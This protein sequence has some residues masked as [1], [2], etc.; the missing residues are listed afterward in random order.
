MGER[1]SFG[2][3][4]DP[5][6][7][8]KLQKIFSKIITASEH[9]LTKFLSRQMNPPSSQIVHNKLASQLLC[10]LLDWRKWNEL[11]LAEVSGILPSVISAHLSGQRPIRPQHLAAYL[12]VLDRQERSALLDAW[13]QDN[14]RSE[15]ATN[16][17]EGTKT[18]SMRSVEENRCR[19]LDWW[20][21]AIAR[22]SKIAKIFRRFSTKAAFKHPLQLLSLVSTIGLQFQ[23]RLLERACSLFARVK[24]A[25]VALVSLILALCQPGKVTQQ[26]GE[27]AEQGGELAGKAIASSL[28]A[29]SFVAPALAEA[30]NVNFDLSDPSPP[31]G[32]RKA[33]NVS[34]VIVKDG[35]GRSQAQY[36]VA[37]GL[38]IQRTIGHEWRRLFTARKNVH[39]A[40]GRLIRDAHPRQFKQTQ[41]KQRRS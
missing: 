26:A 11:K 17:L 16:L 23:G 20:A 6:Q 13:L 18:D 8:S 2:Y 19:M 37:P 40:F 35:S 12:R 39:S 10:R 15:V 32:S 25:T 24:H 22:D 3:M 36:Q 9:V 29:T 27:L 28:F 1:S 21:T 30:T 34:R 4:L 33:R 31:V 7:L 38:R 41:R 5:A 14:V